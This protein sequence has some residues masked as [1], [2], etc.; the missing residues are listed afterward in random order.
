MRRHR[1]ITRIVDQQAK[2]AGRIGRVFAVR[3]GARLSRGHLARSPSPVGHDR[4]MVPRI[5][6]IS[7]TFLR[8]VRR[9]KL[10]T[11]STYRLRP[12]ERYEQMGKI[13]QARGRWDTKRETSKLQSAVWDVLAASQTIASSREKA[14]FKPM[15]QDDGQ[16]RGQE[17]EQLAGDVADFLK[18]ASR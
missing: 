7:P 5:R 14:K 2:L 3:K 1:A 15:W 17:D 10:A 13:A 16:D 11:E 18:T 12:H 6:R 9:V 4:R 8:A